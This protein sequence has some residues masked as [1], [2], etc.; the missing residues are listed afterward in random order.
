MREAASLS[1]PVANGQS[2][3]IIFWT[4]AARAVSTQLL[5]CILAHAFAKTK[6]GLGINGEKLNSRSALNGI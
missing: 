3:G 1:S 4:D 6:K 5:Y 2:K